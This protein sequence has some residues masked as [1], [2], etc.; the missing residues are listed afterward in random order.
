MRSP[1]RYVL[2]VLLASIAVLAQPGWAES[3]PPANSPLGRWK[4]VDDITGKAKSIVL[5]WEQNGKLFGRVQKLLNP[6]PQDPNPRCVD[7]SGEKKGKPVVGMQI[8]QDLS[9]DGD[10][11]SGG[12]I[13]DPA[14]G[15]IYKCLVSVLDGGAKLKVRG[16][17]GVSLLGR[18]QYW[19]RE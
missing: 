15:K 6:D 11:W 12:T 4:T 1:F 3:S 9:K 14:T 18:T 8:M 5:I 7:C 2:P 17:I 10:G 13:L 19:Q 16:F